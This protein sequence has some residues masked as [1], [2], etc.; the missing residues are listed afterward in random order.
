MNRSVFIAA[1]LLGAS[2]VI[3]MASTFVGSNNL[4]LA[5]TLIIGCVYAIGFMELVQFRVATSTLTKGLA[6]LPEVMDDGVQLEQWLVKLHAS[7]RNAVA[8]RIEGER[9]GLP[10]PVVTPYLVGLLVML[11]LLGTFVGMV[12]TLSG[13]VI[14]LEGTTELQAIREGLAA[15]IAGLSVA[16]GTSVAGIAASA[17]L[18]LISTLTRRDRMLATRVLDG[19]ISTVFRCF[20]L[21]YNRAET[22]KALQMQAQT[23]PEVAQ[24]L[25]CVAE[26]LGR[27]SEQLSQTLIANQEQFHESAQHGYSELA[28]SVDTS[29]KTSLAD[30]GRM[31][32]ESIKPV[33]EQA[34]A[35]M[36]RDAQASHQVLTQT[37][38]HQLESL[39]ATFSS[40][41]DAVSAAWQSGLDA[42]GTSN[43]QLVQ[44][45]EGSLN[46]VSDK[47]EGTA[48]ALLDSFSSTSESVSAAWQ[49]GVG[50]QGASN[51]QLVQSIGDSLN[52]V[53][54]KIDGTATSLLD[55]F[56]ESSSAWTKQQEVADE[57]RL[58]LWT[59]SLTESQQQATVELSGVSKQFTEGLLRSTQVQQESLESATASFESM[60]GAVTAQWEGAG[61][62]IAQLNVNLKAGLDSLRDTEEQRGEAAVER[63][64]ALE[65]TVATHLAALGKEMEA[66]MARLIETASETPK[67]A[68]EVIGKLRDEVSNNIERDNQL[69][70]ER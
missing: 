28:A 50:A 56:G 46:S 21:A 19:K 40:T 51:E 3:W 68:A 41:S 5:V 38:Q 54:D 34:M 61:E 58:E 2:A 37:A 63:L 67:A 11:G 13:A 30:S 44:S 39:A 69:L 66:P 9:V 15:P 33:V 8:L 32:G 10:A 26:Q 4:A 65:A 43:E 49:S 14:A 53:T 17:M 70:E 59:A 29:L 1:F 16:F 42:Q 31:A 25:T 18:G 55:A 27:A 48:T 57:A 64:G 36:S 24:K 47:I 45:I 22:Y 20:S 62:Q 52:S 60:S 6:Q 35:Q 12:E 7:L 23:L